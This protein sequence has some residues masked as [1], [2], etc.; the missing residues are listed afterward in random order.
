MSVVKIWLVALIVTITGLLYMN[1][2]I[3]SNVS[4]SANTKALRVATT[5]QVCAAEKNGTW[6]APMV[7]CEQ[8]MINQY[9]DN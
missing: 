5:T 2:C 1:W 7:T 6:H 4:E 3:D 9:E 8:A